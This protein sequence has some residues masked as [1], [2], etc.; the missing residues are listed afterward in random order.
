MAKCQL[1]IPFL[2]PDPFTKKLNL[3]LWAMRSII[4]EWKVGKVKEHT[5]PIVHYRMPIVS[6]IRFGKHQRRCASKSSILND[7][8]SDSQQNLFFRRNNPGGH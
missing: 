3:P 4:K 2:L 7:I 8:I 5:E 1:A 6:F